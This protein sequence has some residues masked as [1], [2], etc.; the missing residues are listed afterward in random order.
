MQ[1][2]LKLLVTELCCILILF[3]ADV[4]ETL[5][6]SHRYILY[7]LS[8]NSKTLETET[9]KYED[10]RKEFQRRMYS[11]EDKLSILSNTNNGEDDQK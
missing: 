6:H 8:I 2:I 3:Y 4:F 11:L 9:R 5:H 7:C 10:E 1:V